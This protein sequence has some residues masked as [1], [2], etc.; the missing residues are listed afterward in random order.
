MKPKAWGENIQIC[1]CAEWEKL[2]G[3]VSQDCLVGIKTK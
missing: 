1:L 2:T 3:V